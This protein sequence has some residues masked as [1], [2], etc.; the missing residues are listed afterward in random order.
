LGSHTEP[1]LLTFPGMLAAYN[2]LG[3]IERIRDNSSPAARWIL[4]ASSAKDQRP[5]IDT[6]PVPVFSRAQWEA[7][8]PFWIKEYRAA[9]S[10][11]R[12]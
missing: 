8:S 2:Q 5:T 9:E 11:A 10:P 7:L 12:T 6:K 1:L 4:I 3:V